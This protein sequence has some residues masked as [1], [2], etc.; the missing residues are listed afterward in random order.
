[1]RQYRGSGSASRRRGLP[2]GCREGGALEPRSRLRRPVHGRDWGSA[3][4][5]PWP[6]LARR[7]PDRPGRRNGGACAGARGT[8]PRPA[9]ARTRA[10][11]RGGARA[12]RDLRSRRA[13][14]GAGERG[15]RDDRAPQGS[16]G[17]RRVLGRRGCP[18]SQ[19]SDLPAHHR[20]S[21]FTEREAVASVGDGVPAL[22][23]RR[24]SLCHRSRGRGRLPRSAG[25]RARRCG[26]RAGPGALSRFAL[27]RGL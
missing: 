10:R 21:P 25:L 2:P 8:C 23:R 22:P 18:P 6:D 16:R 12:R 17:R 26:R 24:C 13:L 15:G 5:G 3:Q 7:S 14:A 11:A 9:R 19:P 4:R 27:W 1:M 20:T